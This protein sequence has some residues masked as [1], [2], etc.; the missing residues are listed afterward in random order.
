[1][2]L[3]HSIVNQAKSN[4]DIIING[5]IGKNDPDKP[6]RFVDGL[7]I[8]QE[9]QFLDSLDL[10][11]LTIRINSGGGDV[12]QGF[13]IM[14]AM[15][16]AKTKI[17]TR[18]EGIAASMGAAILV[19]G[20]EVEMFDFTIVMIHDPKFADDH[21]P[22]NESEQQ[23]I[24]T[25]KA[26]LVT[27]L[28]NRSKMKEEEIK[29]LMTA[30]SF[31]GA[32]KAKKLGI[33]NRVLAS[34]RSKELASMMSELGI[35]LEAGTELSELQEK[36]LTIQNKFDL[37]PNKKS[38]KKVTEILGLD[39]NA[40]EDQIAEAI[41]KI[42]NE[43]EEAAEESTEEEGDEGED[44]GDDAG[45]DEGEGDAGSDEGDSTNDEIVDELAGNYVDQAIADGKIN[46]KARAKFMGMARTSGLKELKSVLGSIPARKTNKS[47][48]SQL[49]G[50]F[51]DE[52]A[53]A[54]TDE[55]KKWSFRDWEKND[56][57]GLENM[58]ETNFDAFKKL[59]KAEYKTEYAV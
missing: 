46:S 49:S 52:G 29:E 59:F 55:Q 16:A 32:E 58:K 42:K 39:E 9:I 12:F 15:M 10:D 25:V 36:L 23:M 18:N 7:E 41:Q 30:E 4:A 1:M 34:T 3:K 8:A 48:N 43:S 57:A 26:S 50:G 56:P 38:M 33:T 53:P 54:L 2:E 51:E 27:V 19:S 22:T 14:S 17:V 11:Q 13:Q 40:T 44:E 24:D 6:R 37:E 31:I 28:K 5:L 45:D 21:P 20:D 47:I 35:D